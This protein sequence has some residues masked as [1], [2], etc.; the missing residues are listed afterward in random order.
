[1]AGL[2]GRFHYSVDHKGRLSLPA[3]IRKLFRGRKGWRRFIVTLGLDECLFVYPAAEWEHTEAKLRELRRFDRK[4]R[5]FIRSIMS[6]A[7]ET[8]LDA[9]GRISIP[10]SLLEMA[11]IK[12]EV[13]IIGALDLI[14]I[15]DPQTFRKYNKRSNLTYEQAAQDLLP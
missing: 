15:W 1:M 7:S 6:N 2:I 4:T 8:E 14:E 5:F 12:D 11:H 13:L 10:Q 3:R 9:Q